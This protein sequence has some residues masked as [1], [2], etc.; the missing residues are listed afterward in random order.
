V[1][2]G[3]WL[4][5]FAVE[6]KTEREC[7]FLQK[8]KKQI[9]AVKERYKHLEENRQ[10]MDKKELLPD[11][12]KMKEV[13]EKYKGFTENTA[14]MSKYQDLGKNINWQALQAG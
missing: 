14:N 4:N 11:E 13:Y 8:N 6:C 10:T 9:E 5:A 3:I 1:I 12:R 7:E 2:A